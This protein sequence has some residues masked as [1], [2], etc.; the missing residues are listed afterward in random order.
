MPGGRSQA[1]DPPAGQGR[2]GVREARVRRSGMLAMRRTCLALLVLWP[3]AGSAETPALCA[4]APNQADGTLCARRK[5]QAAEADLSRAE[6]ALRD[7]LDPVGRRNLE[8]AQQAWRLFRDRE[9]DLETGHDA[10]QP[11]SGGT[12]MPML[13]GE[14]AVTLTARR[15]RD[16]TDQRACPGGDL[17]CER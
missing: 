2:Q 15:T 3:T 17:S 14:C 1:P 8:R 12:I 11:G 16:L 4:D 9:C 7:R 13:L 6:A 5:L 10:D